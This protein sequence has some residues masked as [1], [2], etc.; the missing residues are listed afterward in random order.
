MKAV[1]ANLL[2]LLKKST[3]FV[4]PIYQR[5]YSWVSRSVDS[6]GTMWFELG[7]EPV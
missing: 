5:V 2:E 3:Q 4:V 1:D 7:S 6:F